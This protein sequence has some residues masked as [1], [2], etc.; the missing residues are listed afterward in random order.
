MPFLR[1][2]SAKLLLNQVLKCMTEEDIQLNC[3][4]THV[5][6]SRDRFL[7]LVR[8]LENECSKQILKISLVFNFEPY[9]FLADSLIR[10]NT[11]GHRLH[12]INRSIWFVD[13]LS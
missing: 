11:Q 12:Q 2:T 9:F 6:H 4:G 7:Q 1:K 13:R 5:K 3:T 8:R 10:Q